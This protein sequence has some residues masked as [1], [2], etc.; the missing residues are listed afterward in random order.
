MTVA[1]AGVIG[2]AWREGWPTRIVLSAL[3]ALQIIW[4]G[5][6]Y[7]IPGHAMISSPAKVA[8]DLIAQGFKKGYDARFEVFGSFSAVSRELPKGARVLI[9]EEHPH[10]GIGAP[11]IN[12]YPVNQGGISYGR[13]TKP[14]DVYDLFK[15]YGVTHIVW[16]TR[17]GAENDSLAGDLV[18]FNFVTH[19]ALGAKVVGNLTLGRMPEVPPPSTAEP[20]PVAILACKGGFVTGLYHLSDLHVP[21]FGPAATRFPAPFRTARG[22]DPALVSAAAAVAVETKCAAMPPSLSGDFTMVAT[23]KPYDLFVRT[24]GAAK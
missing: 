17:Q 12:D 19:Y 9:H 14:R 3:V 7:F 21:P 16:P 5:D 8:M 15:S 4:G 11:S 18:F 13:L 24:S 20:D 23:R 2:L 1:T 10:A 6:V 22:D